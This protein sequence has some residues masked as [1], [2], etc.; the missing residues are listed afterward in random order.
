MEPVRTPAT[1]TA[2]PVAITAHFSQGARQ[3]SDDRAGNT[4]K[5][6]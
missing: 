1:A 6:T 4:A 2:A 3:S 5:K